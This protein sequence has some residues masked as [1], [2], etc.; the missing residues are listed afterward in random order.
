[1]INMN[2]SVFTLGFL[3]GLVLVEWVW[4][5]VITLQDI[6]KNKIEK[7]LHE[8]VKK[9]KRFLY[10]TSDEYYASFPLDTLEG[11]IYHMKT[12]LDKY[13]DK[14]GYEDIYMEEVD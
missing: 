11:R 5:T 1:M 2:W 7:K 12:T 14:L 10:L 13:C 9:A 6:K 4:F 8:E 3:S